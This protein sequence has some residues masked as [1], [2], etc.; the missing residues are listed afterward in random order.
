MGQLCG[1]RTSHSTLLPCR[2]GVWAAPPARWWTAPYPAAVQ[3]RVVLAEDNALLR[4]GLVRLIDAAEGLSLVGAAA[5]LPT[6]QELIDREA[7]DV[8]VTDIRM[9]PTHTD[10]GITVAA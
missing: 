5:D 10:E 6:L 8:V 1:R 7:P 9:P 4:S 2:P 3:T